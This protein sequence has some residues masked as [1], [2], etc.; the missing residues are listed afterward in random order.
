MVM[1]S[2]FAGAEMMTFFAPPSMCFLRV[3]GVGEAAG[4]LEHDVDAE[5]LPR[6]LRRI[7][8]GEHLDLVAVDRDRAVAARDV[9]LDT[10]DAPS[11]T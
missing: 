9:A 1:S 11:R 8:L 10:C 6:Q 4:G 5:V 2:P 3:V 7:L